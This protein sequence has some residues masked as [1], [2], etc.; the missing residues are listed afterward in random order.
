M[1]GVSNLDHGYLPLNRMKTRYV[2]LLIMTNQRIPIGV[3]SLNGDIE[4]QL[5]SA[6]FS[7]AKRPWCARKPRK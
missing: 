2:W 6:I 4:V 5:V 3:K 7:Y 1:V